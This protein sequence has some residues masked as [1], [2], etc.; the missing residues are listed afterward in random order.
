M[1]IQI[2]QVLRSTI[3]QKVKTQKKDAP[4][5]VYSRRTLDDSEEIKLL[6][7]SHRILQENSIPN[8]LDLVEKG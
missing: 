1:R 4:V 8:G 2:A 3:E 7:I 6:R 5:Q